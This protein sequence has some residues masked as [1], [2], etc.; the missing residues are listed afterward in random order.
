MGTE[1]KYVFS[2]VKMLFVCLFLIRA[3]YY[4]IILS[5]KMIQCLNIFAVRWN[6]LP[7]VPHI[8]HPII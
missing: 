7:Q 2:A 3:L 4:I 1:I 8:V 5:V 6:E